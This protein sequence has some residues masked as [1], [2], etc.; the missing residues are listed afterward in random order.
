MDHVNGKYFH[1]E[2]TVKWGIFCT[3]VKCNAPLKPLLTL[4]STGY[5]VNA[6]P[7]ARTRITIWSQLTLRNFANRII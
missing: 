4:E 5:L 7:N 6:F 1:V 2:R 3:L